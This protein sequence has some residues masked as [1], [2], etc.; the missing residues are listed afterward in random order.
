MTRITAE[1][2]EEGDLEGATEDDIPPSPPAAPAE[3]LHRTA[4]KAPQCLLGEHEM[5]TLLTRLGKLHLFNPARLRA[6]A[7]KIS[8][9]SSGQD[10]LG[11]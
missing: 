11:E 7:S 2:V 4:E 1:E 3:V 6:A 8:R 5:E 9:R 10:E